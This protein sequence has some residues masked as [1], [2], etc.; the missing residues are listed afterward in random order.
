MT[1]NK[2]AYLG[3]MIYA[4]PFVVFGILHFMNAPAMAAFVPSYVPGGAFWVYL[5][6][7]AFLLAAIAFFSGKQARL[8]GILLAVLLGLFVLTIHIPA[9]AGGQMASSSQLLKDLALAGGALMVASMFPPR[10]VGPASGPTGGANPT[11]NTQ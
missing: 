1:D 9:V 11:G 2:L 6:G 4:L 8:A 7:L 5:T 10:K 3:R